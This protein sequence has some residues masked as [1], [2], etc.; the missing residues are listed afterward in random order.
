LIKLVLII[1]ITMVAMWYTTYGFNVKKSLHYL[2]FFI[3]FVNDCH[4][5]EWLLV[6]R[7]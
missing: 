3:I 4:R 7:H 6:I 2:T 1:D 5:Q